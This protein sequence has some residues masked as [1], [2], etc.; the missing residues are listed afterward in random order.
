MEK[1]LLVALR[2]GIINIDVCISVCGLLLLMFL[3]KQG[4]DLPVSLAGEQF[5]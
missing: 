3:L 2:S 4:D 5:D 1:W